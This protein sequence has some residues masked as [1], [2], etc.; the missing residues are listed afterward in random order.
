MSIENLYSPTCSDCRR[1]TE[2]LVLRPTP[3]AC[4]AFPDGIPL[5]I[6]EGRHDH[7]TPYPGDHGIQFEELTEAD[8]ARYAAEEGMTLEAWRADI[9]RELGLAGAARE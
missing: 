5:D 8:F 4:E 9:E 3:Y 2:V 6:W 1:K 7:K